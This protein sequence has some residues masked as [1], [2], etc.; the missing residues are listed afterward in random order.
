LRYIQNSPDR[1]RALV[2]VIV[3]DRSN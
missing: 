2:D 3:W 1:L